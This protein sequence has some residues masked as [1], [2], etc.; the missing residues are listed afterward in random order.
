MTGSSSASQTVHNRG[1][2][3]AQTDSP[4][5]ADPG[6]KPTLDSSGG[7][8]RNCSSK[9]WAGITEDTQL[10]VWSQPMSTWWWGTTK[11]LICDG[12]RAS[13]GLSSTCCMNMGS[14]LSDSIPLACRQEWRTLL[15]LQGPASLE[16]IGLPP[17]RG[18]QRKKKRRDDHIDAIT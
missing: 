3:R 10:E 17:L 18:G 16:L 14:Q 12:T 11:T 1:R 13:W 6:H 8:K 5:G 7:K 9:R 4:S 15:C 2:T